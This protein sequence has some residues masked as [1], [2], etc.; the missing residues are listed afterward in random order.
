MCVCIYIYMS[1]WGVDLIVS[2]PAPDV[3]APS[4]T[5]VSHQG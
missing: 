4:A 2:E 1:T 3:L 5:S